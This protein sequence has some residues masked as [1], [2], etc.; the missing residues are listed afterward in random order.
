MNTIKLQKVAVVGMGKTGLSVVRHLHRL[1]IECECFDESFVKLPEDLKDIVLHSG[2][3][4]EEAFLGFDKII[5][6]PGIDWRHPSLIQARKCG[7]EIHGDLDE[8]L[9]VYKCTL[10]AITGT[11]GKTTATQMVELL[12]ETLPGG[13]DAGGNIGVPMLDL[14]AGKQ[15]E[16]VVLEL[17]S[18]QL[19]RAKNIHP[20]YAVLLNVQPD[21]ED[22]HE[23]A[24][25]YKA[26]KLSMFS[27]MNEGDT[28]LLSIDADWH[29]MTDELLARGVDVKRFGVID[30]PNQH[31]VAGVLCGD[32]GDKLFWQQGDT[33]R[34]ID[35]SSLLVRGRHQHQNIAVAAQVAADYNVSPAVIEEALMSFQGL[36][37]RLEF[38]GHIAGRDWYNDSKATNPNAAIA[39]LQSFEK[40]IWICGGLRKGL[41][42][43]TLIDVVKD[44]VSFA[45]VIG[46]EAQAYKEMLEQSGVPYK[47][48]VTMEQAVKDAK[49]QGDYPVLL[50]PAAASQDQY[51]H[52]A[53]R[54]LDFIHEIRV[55]NHDK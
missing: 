16:R 18:F 14:L 2:T 10:I 44:H 15:P 45:C 48:S 50:S 8:F 17:S 9:D 13:C 42:L 5:V 55:R 46:E 47:V 1:N 43:D 12:L 28:A 33:Q 3:L 51:Q 35:C 22:M 41:S 38:V 54:G 34:M 31:V 53:A 6:S 7:I 37:H 11:N 29:D 24:E 52:Y 20:N 36:E 49:M 23:S 4:S 32:N 30:A 27:L 25:A 19:E 39:A 40:V 26:A 21:H